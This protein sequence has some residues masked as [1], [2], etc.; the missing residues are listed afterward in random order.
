MSI[1]TDRKAEL[2]AQ[3]KVTGID[4]I[5]VYPDQ[6]TLDIYFLR[7]VTT[8]DVPMPDSLLPSSI[9]IYTST[10]K[11]PQIEIDVIDSWTTINDQ[12]VLRVKTKT[13]GDFS[14]YNLIISDSRIDPFFND[15]SFSF[16][17][18]C[19]SDLDCKLREHECPPDE[20]I[21]F[22]IDYLARD[23]W[24]FRSALLDFA[25]LRYPD[26]ADRL[27]AD[28]GVMMAE[29]MSSLGDEMACYQDRVNRE[30]YLETATQRRSVR[31]HARLIDYNITD[32]L[33]AKGWLDFT[34]ASGNKI[35]PAGTNVFSLSDDNTRIDFE[36][37]QGLIETIRGKTYSVSD[38]SNEFSP[39]LWDEN[40]TCLSVGTTELYIE[41]HQKS[42][43]AFDDFPPG[44][45]SGKWILIKTNPINPA[46]PQRSQ[47][48]RLIEVTETVDPVFNSDITHLIWEEDG[49][50]KNEFELTILS[51]RGNMVPAT[52]GKT[53]DAYFIVKDPLACLS[54]EQLIAFP[55]TLLGETV[56][57]QG[58]DNKDTYLFTL[59][60]SQSQPLVYLEDLETNTPRPEISLEEVVFD[61]LSNSWI[62]K[63]FSKPWEYNRAMVGVHSAKSLDNQFT[64]DDGSWQRVVGYQRIG[65]EFVHEDYSNDKGSTIRFGDGE[66]GRRPA[67]GNVFKV[68]YRLGGPKQSNVAEKTLKYIPTISDVTVTNPLPTSGGSDAETIDQVKQLA[69]EAFRAIAYRAVRPED[70]SEAAERLP[71]V[72]KAGSVSRWTGSWLTTFTTPDSKETVTLKE[73]KRLDLVNQLNRFRQAGREVNVLDPIYADIDLEIKICISE[74]SYAGQVKERVY[75]ALFGKTGF[76]SIIGYFSPERFTFGTPLERS[77]LEAAIQE[78]SGVKAV[79]K[80]YFRRRGWFKSRKFSEMS[81]DPGKD[82]IIRVSNNPLHPEQGTLKLYTHGGL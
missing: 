48:V 54:P 12:D 59:P 63:P 82:A 58:H 25:S 60:N 15:I 16:K 3:S 67:E 13:S 52:A 2:L 79:E 66:F 39:H 47:I 37:G 61:T 64:L 50:L 80:I 30:A 44:K 6:K 45:P 31:R 10:S 18:N 65:K 7:P 42:A 11:L 4:F 17:A 51:I 28:A 23:F 36:V 78:V 24:S 27:E 14:L 43:L 26:W 73:D 72:Q 62:S 40:D 81:Y 70:Y 57:R 75:N 29:L 41:G 76:R 38:Q 21:D 1:T 34:V 71:W 35:I 56:N 19:P 69:P 74:N 77:T 9:I 68:Q 20:Q 53:Y 46:Q 8:L 49:A 22:P 5:Y 33:G 32:E 55:Q